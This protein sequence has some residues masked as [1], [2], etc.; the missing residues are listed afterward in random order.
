MRIELT[1][2]NN[3]IIAVQDN[4]GIIPPQPLEERLFNRRNLS[5][6]CL[7]HGRALVD[8]LYDDHGLISYHDNK[9]A[10]ATLLTVDNK[11]IMRIMGKVAESVI[12]R[13]CS[14][15]IMLNRAWMRV[16]SG[17]NVQTETARRYRAVGTGFKSTKLRYPTVYNPQDTQ[18]DIIWL[19]DDGYRYP[20]HGSSSS[21][22]K[23]AGL[24]I[25]ISTDGMNYIY[26]DLLNANYEVPVAYFD[27]NDDYGKI[28]RRL[29]SE[30]PYNEARLIENRF[31]S[32]KEYDEDAYFE[33]EHYFELVKAVV[34]GQITIEDLIRRAERNPTFGSAV[35]ASAMQNVAGKIF[36]EAS[37]DDYTF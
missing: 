26:S 33:A 18:R 23:D 15:S 12:A 19:D 16:A 13:R 25:K 21:A 8:I 32:V 3:L 22:A 30:L 1:R 10:L 37:H 35:M 20:V 29:K 7:E 14:R 6:L 17:T 11:S 2:P 28:Y 24:Q 31:I 5:L 34:H 9:L 27:L 4:D 36:L